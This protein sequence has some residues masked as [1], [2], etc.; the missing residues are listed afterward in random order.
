MGCILYNNNIDYKENRRCCGLFTFTICSIENVV[1]KLIEYRQQLQQ[2]QKEQ[3]IQTILSNSITIKTIKTLNESI[4][5][6]ELNSFRHDY[7]N[8]ANK[9]QARKLRG[10]YNQ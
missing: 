2:L 6:N 1:N 10:I 9:S 5:T 4:N 7:L 3:P 8:P